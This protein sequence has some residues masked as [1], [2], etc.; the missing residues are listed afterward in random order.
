MAV[1]K[2]HTI[3]LSERYINS[4]IP[5]NNNKLEISMCN[6]VCYDNPSN[7][8]VILSVPITKIIQFG[9]NSD[10]KK[11]YNFIPTYRLQSPRQDE[12][13]TFL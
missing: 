4:T 6:L 7:K 8:K 11:K 13:P 10:R 2:F 5:S 12:F 9:S 1:Y 3:C